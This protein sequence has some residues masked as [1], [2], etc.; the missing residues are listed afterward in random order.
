MPGGMTHTWG[1]P[2]EP[3]RRADA[4]HEFELTHSSPTMRYA[5][6]GAPVW[7]RLPPALLPV[8]ENAEDG[9]ARFQID[10][11]DALVREQGR[12]PAAA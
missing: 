12:G 10:R 8:N 9:I 4:F 3:M 5:I 7:A 2:L 1:N 6:L 11:H